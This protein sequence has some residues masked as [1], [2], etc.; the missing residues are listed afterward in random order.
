GL[1][2]FTHSFSSTT[3]LVAHL[4][5]EIESSLCDVLETLT[6]T[7]NT[8]KKCEACQQNVNLLSHKEK[9]IT[10]LQALGFSDS[11]D[12]AQAWL[13]LPSKNGLQKYTHRPGLKSARPIDSNF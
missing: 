11:D 10:I 4:L 13:S 2:K 1:M 9:I 12:V 7:A 8:K 6:D 3:N 5:R